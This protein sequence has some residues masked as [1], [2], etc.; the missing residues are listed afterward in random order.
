MRRI[1][2][3]RHLTPRTQLPDV[4]DIDLSEMIMQLR[5]Q[6]FAYQAALGATARAAQ[7]SLM[8]FLR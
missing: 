3:D 7:P 4:D 8:E 5:L 6:E 1:A 2:E